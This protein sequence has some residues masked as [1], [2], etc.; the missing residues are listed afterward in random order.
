MS[1]KTKEVVH[2]NTQ[3]ILDDLTDSLE[4]EVKPNETPEEP[5]SDKMK[6]LK[7]RLAAMQAGQTSEIKEIKMTQAMQEKPKFGIKMGIVG[8]GQAGSRLAE[9]FHS[10]GYDAV[11]MN[12][13]QQ[14]LRNIKV[15][16]QQS[17]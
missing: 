3:N 15:H 16:Q 7:A 9:E 13:A 10:L 14:D 4:E 11:V 6:E 12:T 8:S 17:V 1:V 5:V 2:E